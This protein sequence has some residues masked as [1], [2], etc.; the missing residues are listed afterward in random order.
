MLM[1]SITDFVKPYMVI[2]FLV[3]AMILALLTIGLL[4]K[5]QKIEIAYADNDDDDVPES[6]SV[7]E[8][9]GPNGSLENKT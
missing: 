9:Q 2:I 1:L 6:E 4:I 8:N 3:V 7:V 5:P